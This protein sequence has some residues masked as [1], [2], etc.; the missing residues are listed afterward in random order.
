MNLGAFFMFFCKNKIMSRAVM[1]SRNGSVVSKAITDQAH[2]SVQ[3]RARLRLI[4][5]SSFIQV[6]VREEV[7]LF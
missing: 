2:L 4:R 1:I 7:V 3:S 5:V 6:F